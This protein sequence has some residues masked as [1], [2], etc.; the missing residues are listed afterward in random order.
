MT[1]SGS[2]EAIFHCAI[3]NTSYNIYWQVNGSDADFDIYHQ[4]GVSIMQINATISRLHI[5]GYSS[6]NHT[7]VQCIGVL[8]INHHIAHVERSE[9]AVLIVLGKYIITAYIL[10]V[11]VL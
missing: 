8:F 2:E 4:R 11:I 7:T 3:S 5:V 9:E 10:S 6:N 1:V